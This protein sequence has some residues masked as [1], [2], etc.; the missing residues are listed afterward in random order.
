M[1][2]AVLAVGVMEMAGDEVI[3]VVAV[4]H[5]FVT[6]AGAV[7]VPGGVRGAFVI[8]RAS[9]R[10][11]GGDGEAVLVRV[12]AMDV[13]EVTVMQV[14]GVAIVEDGEVAATRTVR[15]RFGMLSVR[16]A[17]GGEE[18]GDGKRGEG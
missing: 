13:V 3:R 14:V 4:G 7:R 10:V 8:R 11:C 2:V 1:V 5:G 15:V 6:A 9:V 12:G 17:A 18:R 16:G